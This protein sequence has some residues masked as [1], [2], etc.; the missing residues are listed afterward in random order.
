MYFFTNKRKAEQ[1]IKRLRKVFILST[2]TQGNN[3]AIFGYER[4]KEIEQKRAKNLADKIYL[5]IMG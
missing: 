4:L 5:E 1:F 3:V 2:F